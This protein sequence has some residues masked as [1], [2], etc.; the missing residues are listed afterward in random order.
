MSL[1]K[2]ADSY[3]AI[4]NQKK[5]KPYGAPTS[6]IC[7]GCERSLRSQTSLNSHEKICPNLRMGR[8]DSF[9]K[10]QP[11]QAPTTTEGAVGKVLP[12]SQSE[13][14]LSNDEADSNAEDNNDVVASNSLSG[15]HV[16]APSQSLDDEDECCPICKEGPVQDGISC[17]M[18][19]VWSHQVCL[20]MSDD[21]FQ[22]LK[23]SDTTQWFC[24][25]C[26]SIQANNLHWGKY[27]GEAEIDGKIKSIY[28]TV[29]NWKKNIFRLPRGKSGDNFLKEMARLINLFARKT[30]WERI[31]LSL[32]HIFVPIMMQKPSAKS[33]P[34][35]HA[36][37]LT[38][39][40]ERWKNGDLDSI[41]AEAAEIQKNLKND[42][43]KEKKKK[44]LVKKH[45]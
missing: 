27:N 17:D 40:L 5:G 31:A 7:R 22:T 24:A 36:R 28:N 12:S 39:R 42:K 8:L 23:D 14:P 21:E 15:A 9:S 3:T 11:L 33:K 19:K 1:S 34:R 6:F 29:L 26:L 35:D 13:S 16:I 45:S 37:Y 20:D 43:R 41:M 18:C 4:V 30:A 25:R 32:F 10:L 2:E 44:K 38:T